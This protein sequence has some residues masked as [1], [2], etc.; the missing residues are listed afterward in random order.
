MK[1]INI[2]LSDNQVFFMKNWLSDAKEAMSDCYMNDFFNEH[3]ESAYPELIGE[4]IDELIE[5]GHEILEKIIE[6][7]G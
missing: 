7:L 2:A 6:Q 1:I 3:Y 5:D 4:E